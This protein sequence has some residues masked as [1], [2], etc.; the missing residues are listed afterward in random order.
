MNLKK[1]KAA[2]KL[3]VINISIIYAL[4]LI[5][6]L[7][8]IEDDLTEDHIIVNI[9]RYG[10]N[11]KYSGFI[12]D[13]NLE[14]IDGEVDRVFKV[15]T[16]E[17]GDIKLE[18]AFNS[19]D[20]KIDYL[21]MGGS[22][23]ECLYVN[24]QMR[25]PYLINKS[26]DDS[27]HVVNLSKGG[28][29]SHHSFL[30]LNTQLNENQINNLILMHN[31]NDLVHLLFFNSY[32]KGVTTRRSVVEYDD[33]LETNKKPLYVPYNLIDILKH[34]ISQ[35]YPSLYNNIKKIG[36]LDFMK[37]VDEFQNYRTKKNK[38]DEIIFKK[39][40]NN[41]NLFV[42]T[43]NIRGTN[44]IL[45]T[46]FNRFEPDDTFVKSVYNRSDNVLNYEKFIFA[47]KKFNDIIRKVALENNLKLVDLDSL[48]PKNKEYM[49]DSV[50]LTEKGS[51]L[52]ADEILKHIK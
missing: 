37:N 44:L 4:L 21:F 45:M 16:G 40:E 23:T 31:V 50:H 19:S 51:V 11:K 28:K 52:V 48:I 26:L 33:L 46:Q 2:V 10:K 43:A 15:T 32:T 7:I 6:N 1:I 24:P 49:F 42:S 12:D 39:F 20:S 8:I 18:K 5:I 35:L 22:T 14:R 36:F 9:K 3:L 25:F 30:Q 27:I 29:H 47:Y 38:I 41:L 13:E 34:S 17:L